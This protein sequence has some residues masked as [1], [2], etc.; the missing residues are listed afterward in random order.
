MEKPAP[1][2]FSKQGEGH[3]SEVATGRGLL[4]GLLKTNWIAVAHFGP[5]HGRLYL[6]QTLLLGDLTFVL[7]RRKSRARPAPT[8]VEGATAPHNLFHIWPAISTRS[9]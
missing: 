2:V 1:P 9:D 5:Y 7:C 6:K 3:G 4:F 8:R